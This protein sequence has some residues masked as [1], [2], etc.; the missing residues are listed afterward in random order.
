MIFLSSR[1]S[2]MPATFWRAHG[3]SSK[4]PMLT[5][6]RAPLSGKGTLPVHGPIRSL[7][8]Y[9]EN[10]GWSTVLQGDGLLSS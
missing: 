5:L 9:R 10:V 7:S 1:P 6:K 3:P 2:A 4:R 8:Q